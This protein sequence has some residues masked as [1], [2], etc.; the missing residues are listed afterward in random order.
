MRA[1]D[2]RAASGTGGG[3]LSN[4]LAKGVLGGIAAYGL[5]RLLGGAHHGG[6]HRGHH[7]HSRHGYGGFE[8]DDLFEG[9]GFFGGEDE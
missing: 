1:E 4:P 8:V 6:N 2:T 7:G 3:M 9:G 5:S